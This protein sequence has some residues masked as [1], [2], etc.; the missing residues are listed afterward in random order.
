MKTTYQIFDP[1]ARV[2]VAALLVAI[3]FASPTHA[4]SANPFQ[5]PTAGMSPAHLILAQ[6]TAP[7]SPPASDQPSGPAAAPKASRAD[8]V[9]TR[10][11]DLHDRL[12]ITPEQ[13]D[14]WKNLA[15]VMRDNSKTMQELTK[16][17]K[18]KA[19]TV[20][21]VDDLK[22]YA[23]ITEA[24]ADGLKKFIPAFESLYS[25]MSDEQKKNADTIFRRGG[26]SR[27]A[28]KTTTPKSN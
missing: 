21:A 4:A 12:N 13:E 10:I 26:R 7:Q 24:H 28:S 9:E 3:G 22:S 19:K 8:R 2:F 1:A 16:A 17:R 27:A 11:K 25:T 20:N 14:Q 23:E 18:E 6:A 15:Q 5:A